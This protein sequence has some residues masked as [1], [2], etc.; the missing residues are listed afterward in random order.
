M[1]AGRDWLGCLLVVH[2]AAGTDGVAQF[3]PFAVLTG[4]GSV[5]RETGRLTDEKM[6]AKLPHAKRE[7]KERSSQAVNEVV[8]SS[9]VPQRTVHRQWHCP[10]CPACLRKPYGRHGREIRR[11]QPG[12]IGIPDQ[13]P[14]AIHRP[15]AFHAD[16]EYAFV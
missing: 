5:I 9:A 16:G 3:S 14:R 12:G 4:Y 15:T 7:L 10:V 13:W 6:N 1:A 11:C 8:H 2:C